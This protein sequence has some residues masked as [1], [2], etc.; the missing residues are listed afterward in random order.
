MAVKLFQGKDRREIN[1]ALNVLIALGDRDDK[2]RDTSK[3]TQALS[4]R[5][6]VFPASDTAL[7]ADVTSVRARLVAC[8]A[9]TQ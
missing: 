8:L 1:K 3:K 6:E 2:A 7:T 4:T 9:M 5:T